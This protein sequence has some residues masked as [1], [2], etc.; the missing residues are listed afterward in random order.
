MVGFREKL[1]NL[2]A[3]VFPFQSEAGPTLTL[4][5]ST[6]TQ[7]YKK[8]KISLW[9]PGRTLRRLASLRSS[10]QGIHMYN[11]PKGLAF[12]RMLQQAQ[13]Q[14]HVVVAVLPLSP[15]YAGEFLTPQVKQAF[16]EVL[17]EAKRNIPTTRWIRLDQL[18]ELKSNDYFW[19]LVH[20]NIYG[21]QIAT[22]AF[23]DQVRK[24]SSL[25]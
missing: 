3:A 9:D 19:D 22:K 6:S 13:K 20:M 10:C 11:G 7:E 12:L 4:N 17:A 21:Q 2:L 8:E 24:F 16:E 14:G 25:P 18:D 15:H 1:K 5:E 23:L